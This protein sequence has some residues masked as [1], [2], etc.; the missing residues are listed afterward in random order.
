MKKLLSL[1]VLIISISSYVCTAGFSSLAPCMQG[2]PDGTF[3]PDSLLKRAEAIQILYNIKGNEEK[4]D[5]SLFSDLHP[6][7]PQDHW[8][9]VAIN[10]AVAYGYI[11]GDE[12]NS[13]RI[14]ENLTRAE[15]MRIVFQ[16]G[17]SKVYSDT[18]Q[19]KTNFTDVPDDF[20][21]QHEIRAISLRANLEGYSDGSFKPDNSITRAECAKI[22]VGYFNHLSI[23]FGDKGIEF[24]DLD[25]PHWAYGYIIKIAQPYNYSLK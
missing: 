8:A 6:D 3:R 23:Q 11:I 10:W 2:F 19:G 14:D 24:T 16:M 13:L 25:Y 4:V 15:F 17:I 9:Q 1:L 18:W 20:W 21:A 22:L 7:Y 12:N 5:N